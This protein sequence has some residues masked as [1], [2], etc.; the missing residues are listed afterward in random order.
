MHK[1]PQIMASK[2]VVR[3][4]SESRVK[5]SDFVILESSLNNLK[6]LQDTLKCSRS[7]SE[8]IKNFLCMHWN[9]LNVLQLLQKISQNCFQS[10]EAHRKRKHIS[11][12]LFLFLYMSVRI[13]PNVKVVHIKII[14][15]QI[16][17]KEGFY[18][19]FDWC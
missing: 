5:D 8:R 17:C 1:R 11:H 3:N 18:Q 14:L 15:H 6:A 10:G 19:R 7:F 16:F 12:N 2:F 13:A 4:F 9:I